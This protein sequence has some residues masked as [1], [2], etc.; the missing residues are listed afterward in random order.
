[1]TPGWIRCITGLSDLGFT[2]WRG[3]FHDNDKGSVET[4]THPTYGQWIISVW[5][6]AYI[7]NYFSVEWRYCTDQIWHFR[8][9]LI[10]IV[11]FCHY[12]LF[13]SVGAEC[14]YS[15]NHCLLKG[16]SFEKAHYKKR[17]S[18]LCKMYFLICLINYDPRVTHFLTKWSSWGTVVANIKWIL[19]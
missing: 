2:F 10:F 11:A 19:V 16:S 14:K 15:Q 6:R 12:G 17:I 9:L 13:S 7:W 8:A 1:M 3:H 18:T 4:L 5:F